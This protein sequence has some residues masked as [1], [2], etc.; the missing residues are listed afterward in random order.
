[1]GVVMRGCGDA[2][3]DGRG[4]ERMLGGCGHMRIEMGSE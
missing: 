1:M 2:G 4:L 3:L